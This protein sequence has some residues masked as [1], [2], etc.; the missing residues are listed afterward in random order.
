VNVL[1]L[2]SASEGKIRVMA[3]KLKD[4]QGTSKLKGKGF[5][6]RNLVYI[7]LIKC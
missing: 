6:P 1:S 4:E 2:Y 7:S 5:E 3:A